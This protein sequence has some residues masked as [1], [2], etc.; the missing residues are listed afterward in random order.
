MKETAVKGAFWRWGRLMF[1][2][3]LLIVSIWILLFL[4]LSFLALK[5]PELLKD[6]GFTPYGSESQDALNL[7]ESNLD[8]PGSLIQLVY[9]SDQFD[10]TEEQAKQDIL[11]SLERVG[12]LS[13]V[14]PI[15]FVN[16]SRMDGNHGVQAVNIPLQ[17]DT[18][19][20]LQEYPGIKE[21][22]HAPDGME[23][24]ITGG[25]AVI[26]DMQEASKNDIIKAEMIGVPIALIVLL[27][28]FG[29]VLG[30]LLPMIVGVMSV[31]ITLGLTY[32]IAHY[33]SLSNFLPNMVTM[34][35]LAVGIDYALFMV[36]RFREELKRQPSLEDAVAMTCQMAGKSI[37]FSGIAVLIGLLSMLFIDLNIFKS[38]SL[39][40]TIV[41]T[42]SVLVA[43]T[44]LLS[45]LG[46]FGHKINI[47]KV[48]P[49]AWKRKKES[50]LWRTVA[51]AVMKRP[52]TLVLILSVVLISLMLPLANMK[53]GVPAAEVLPPTYESRYGFD[54]MNQS[55][56]QRE[57]NP[58]HIAVTAEQEVWNEQSVNLIQDYLVELEGLA[59]VKEIQSYL[60]ATGIYTLD[61]PAALLQQKEI[62]QEL[63]QQKLAGGHTAVIAVIPESDPNGED[64]DELV[65]RIRE[66]NIQGLQTLVTGDAAFRSD[67]IDRIYAGIPNVLIFVVGVTYFV[68]MFAFRSMLLP[69]KAVLMNVLSLG[70]SLG[71]VVSVFQYGYFAELMQITSIGYVNATLPVLIFCV[72]FGISM[73]Y[74]VF[75][76]SRI[77]EEYEKTGDNDLSTAEGLRNT[78]GLITSAALI[79]I[80]VVGTFIFTDIEIM[81]ALGLGLSLAVLIDATLVRIIM[82]PALMKLLGP[83]NW[84]APRWLKPANRK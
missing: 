49:R 68:L 72:V 9:E 78:G 6:N 33:Y 47:L 74:E 54:L 57:L 1:R 25:T 70:A 10:L 69:L 35:G 37:F 84:W 11:E 34:L 23:V 52:V 19:E 13:F 29:T 51:F 22:I 30:A 59:N 24:H 3:R 28:V 8:F 20:A 82:V 15:H 53:L 45:L 40:G 66:L 36:S 56:D 55:Y 65:N 61:Q 16:A 41:V 64:T 2:F 18:D 80:V 71:I 50:N 48:I 67:I 42:I 63:E 75:L 17:L 4:S 26:Y 60:H 83:A 62:Q 76:I 27:I 31:T 77:A 12:E 58:I 73:D 79:L 39:G 5:T 32:F 81:K 38:L 14:D 7:L 21:M 46:M 44:L 43:N